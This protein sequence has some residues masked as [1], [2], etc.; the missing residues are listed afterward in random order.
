MK[1]LEGFNLPGIELLYQKAMEEDAAG[2]HAAKIEP[3]DS[4]AGLE[5]TEQERE[6]WW[7]LGLEAVGKGE[8]ALLVLS[9]GAGT[10]LGFS[11]PKGMYDV[12]LPSGK[13][14]F[15]YQGAKLRRLIDMAKQ[16]TETATQQQFGENVSVPWY[17][18]TSPE[19]NDT[20]AS[21]FEEKAYFGLPAHD[22][23]F[24]AQGTL[25]CLTEEGK[26]IMESGAVVASSPDG[27]GGIYPALQ[28]CGILDDM[29][30]RGV[31]YVHTYAVDNIMCKV[32]DPTF[33]GYC[34]K[35][36]A[37]CGNKVVWKADSNE[38]VGVV[39]KKDGK[40]CVVEYS[41]MSAEQK[42]LKDSNGKLV[43]G[44]GNICNHFY[45]LDF[46]QNI[47]VPSLAEGS[48]VYHVA[49]KKIPHAAVS[50]DGTVQT[51]K[52]TSNNG[53]KCE[54]EIG[55]MHVS[56]LNVSLLNVSLLKFFL[57][58]MPLSLSLPPPSLH[59]CT[60][61]VVETFIFDVFPLCKKM[62]VIEIGEVRY[63]IRTTSF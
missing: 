5:G 44:A 51:V 48:V 28:A 37:D 59:P 38:S 10:R 43:F 15:E 20:C 16:T 50:S 17:V 26:F 4:F 18:M 29:R 3:L 60:L 23:K 34:I 12:G 25:P 21:Y 36:G 62:A 40:S 32:A 30:A 13:T 11:G 7:G 41:D 49:R 58:H 46:L 61:F 22:V 57:L 53:I 31:K 39:A 24:F 2:A 56:L 52:P 63:D 45:T 1:Q 55:R 35:E 47:V 19:N 27:N 54:R 8:V 6:E 33:L 42:E 14:L 9:G